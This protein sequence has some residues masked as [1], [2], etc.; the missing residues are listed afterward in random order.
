MTTVAEATAQP[1]TGLNHIDALL[2]SGPGWNWLAP[3]RTVLYYSFALDAPNPSA[4]GKINGATS[5]FN[6]AQ[7]AATLTA[8]SYVSQV[9]GIVFAQVGSGAAAD[10]HF[11]AAD[12]VGASVSGLCSWNYSYSSSNGNIVSYTADAWIYLD[13]VQ[14]VVDNANPAVGGIG[15]ETL[16]HELGHALGLKHPF[17]GSV[18]LPAGRD[19]TD[20]TLM[21]YTHVGAPQSDYSPYDIA[22]LMWLYGGDGLGGQLGQGTQGQYLMGSEAGDALTGGAGNDTFEGLGGND[23]IRGGAGTD[24]ARFSGNRSQYTITPVGSD[25]TVTGPEGTDTLIAV[26]RA[27]FADQTVVLSASGGN[28]PPTGGVAISGTPR[29]G[30]VL[31]A[32]STLADA[33]GLGPLNWRWQSSLNGSSWADIN[34]ATNATFTPGEAQVGLQLRVQASYTDGQGKAESANSAGSAPVANVNDAPTGAVIVT[35]VAQK[36]QVLGLSQNLADADGIGALSWRWQSSQDGS[37]W[38][39]IPGATGTSFTPGDTL[40]GSRLRAVASWT[41]GHGTAESVPSTATGAV[42]GVNAAPTGALAISG[43]PIQGGVLTVSQTLA[44]AD[45]LGAISYRWQSSPNGSSWSDIAAASGASLI[46][47]EALVGQ[48]IRV[49]AS[50]TDGGGTLES[51]TSTATSAVANVN[52]APSGTVMILGTLKQGAVLSL[53]N[54]LSDPDGIGTLAY[55]W[56]SSSDGISWTDVAGATG[57]SFTPGEPQVGLSLR[58]SVSWID[59]HGSAETVG[60]TPTAAVANVNDAPT[61][62]LTLVGAAE[63]GQALKATNTLADAD[64]L[65]TIS[66]EWQSSSNGNTWIAIDGAGH[67]A[68][69][70]P[71]LAQVGQ[72]LRALARWTDG[73]GTAEAVA[74]NASTGVLGHQVGSSGADSLTGTAFADRLE[75]GDGNDRLQGAGADDQLDGG[76][77]I[78][79]A[80][81]QRPRADYAVGAGATSVKALAGDEGTDTLSQVERLVF[82]D[83]SLAFD[84]S[85]AAGSTARILGAVF[86]REA[87]SNK[88]YAGIGLAQIDGGTD[89][90]ALMQMALQA[91]LGGGFS[92]ESEVRAL[93]QNL[94]GTGPTTDELNFWV[95]E[96]SAGHYT[97]V[98]LAWLAANHD[99]NAQNIDLAGLAGSGL[100]YTS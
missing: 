8:L 42:L 90:S 48:S 72:L 71:G 21:S 18:T 62:S 6:A 97:P 61:G 26:E 28:S 87:V 37:L 68:S 91:R 15:Y 67:E 36:G 38:A 41:D 99:I 32:V 3:A 54:S 5:T 93:Y 81:Y 23:T 96:V 70:T 4:G 55:R 7:Q 33:D 49:L 45:G 66:Y 43:T 50:W 10:L 88:V 25:F 78:D 79:Q 74:S 98:S 13:N 94:L 83:Q 20:Y 30:A 14:W 39:D 86:G 17:E 95:G 75:G 19:N 22:A 16:L 82:S 69:Y 63:Q 53:S 65:G 84:L 9:T 31:S 57:T 89:L 12:I 60:G 73:H 77:G 85:G 1:A 11:G 92:V 58:V 64:G 56:Q 100:A 29:Q 51:V 24:S 47:G 76:A 34:G 46:P 52:D 27:V 2:D 44:D 80:V 35:G 40:I 59:G